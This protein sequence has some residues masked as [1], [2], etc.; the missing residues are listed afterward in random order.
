MSEMKNVLCQQTVL[1]LSVFEHV[2]EIAQ[3]TP[4]HMARPITD[5]GEAGLMQS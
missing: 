4:L 3:S 1:H 2:S 5:T